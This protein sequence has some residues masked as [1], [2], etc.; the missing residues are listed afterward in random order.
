MSI[1]FLLQLHYTTPCK[2]Y[3]PTQFTLLE[4]INY[5]LAVIESS[6]FNFAVFLQ[7]D[8]I[9]QFNKDFL[10]DAQLWLADGGQSAF[11]EFKKLSSS[12]RGAH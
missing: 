11:D 2:K 10:T 5:G 8:T 6:A 9:D 12:E 4:E 3:K 7:K 1:D